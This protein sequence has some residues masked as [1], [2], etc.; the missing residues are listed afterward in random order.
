MNDER[1]SVRLIGTIKAVGPIHISRPGN[2]GELLTMNVVRNEMT[3]RVH[4]LPGGTLKGIMRGAALAVCVDA[5]R[6]TGPVRM[7]LDGFYRQAAGGLN[8]TPEK[9]AL[10]SDEAVRE[11]QPLLSL[12]GCASP[13]M[14]GRIIV[15]HAVA[16]P[17][18]KD[19][20][21]VGTGLP[22]STRQ[23]ALAGDG[24]YADLVSPEDAALWARQQGEGG[25]VGDNAEAKGRLKDAQHKLRRAKAAKMADT[26]ALEAAVGE[27]Q[28]HVDG[29]K[30]NAEFAHA[31]MRLLDSPP[32]APAGTV[33]D[34]VIEVVDGKPEEVGLLFA[35]LQQWGLEPRV[36]G[37]RTIGYGEVEADYALSVLTGDGPP[38]LRRWRDAGS[39][40]IGRDGTELAF[41]HP[42]LDAAMEAWAA[43][44]A[45]ITTSTAMFA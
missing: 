32:A 27:A 19:D 4:V 11:G 31:I 1:M 29:I 26:A 40:H 7:S 12:L 8:F 17:T 39:V 38:R 14:R 37:S 16:R 3:T 36:G 24:G 6:A 5:A 25:I 33:F 20:R 22:Q 35:A 23:D 28:A 18:T 34:H 43:T 10:G 30:G 2:D 9:R 41:A 21:P 42:A 45:S 15:Q 13:K 44:E